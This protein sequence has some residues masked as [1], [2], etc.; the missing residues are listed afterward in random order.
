LREY[1]SDFQCFGELS[2]KLLRRGGFLAI[3]LGAP[4]AESFVDAKVLAEVDRVLGAEG[5]S[6]VWSTW[7]PIQWHRNHGY[8]RLKKERIAVYASE[9]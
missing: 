4:V 1:L 3:V 8:A 2:A 5:F 7:R 9:R 6:M